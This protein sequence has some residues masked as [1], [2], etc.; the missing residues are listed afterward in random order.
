MRQWNIS[1]ISPIAGPVGRPSPPLISNPHQRRRRGAVTSGPGCSIRSSRESEH[2][3]PPASPA[4]Q[5]PRGHGDPPPRP[6]PHP[7]RRAS[8]RRRGGPAVLVR[9][10]ERHG[11]VARPQR[12]P[13]RGGAAAQR[14]GEPGLRR[15]LVELQRA[16]RHAHA[17][18]GH[19]GRQRH[20]H[21]PS[22]AATR[23]STPPRCSSRSAAAISTPTSAAAALCSTSPTTAG[24]SSTAGPPQLIASDQGATKRVRRLTLDDDGN[25]RLYSLVPRTRRWSMVWQ[26]VQDSRSF[27]AAKLVVT[28]LEAAEPVLMHFRSSRARF[29]AIIT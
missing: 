10:R 20:H 18:A 17:G 3:S 12:L 23:W 13:E 5:L 9:R 28:R 15:G 7:P 1:P 24:S 29:T 2:M 26:L 27:D 16:H 8:C 14:H 21:A 6:L 4:Q 19:P 11:L 25:L 22:T